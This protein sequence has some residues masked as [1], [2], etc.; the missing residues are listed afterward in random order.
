[1][2]ERAHW[3]AAAVTKSAQKAAAAH[4]SLGLEQHLAGRLLE[5]CRGPKGQA[6]TISYF[7]CG[8]SAQAQKPEDIIELFGVESTLKII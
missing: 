5:L 4:F 2:R 3:Q 7:Q 6:G 1:M 8:I